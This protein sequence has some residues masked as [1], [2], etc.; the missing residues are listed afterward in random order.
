M[1]RSSPLESKKFRA[2][3]FAEFSWK[4]LL[5]CALTLFAED[6]QHVNHWA[7]WFMMSI[8]VTAGFV[9]IGYIGGQAWLDRYVRVAEI[10]RGKDTPSEPKQS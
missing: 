5:A 6:F 7:W 8:V 9:E 10:A 4:G 1:S 3:M 2:Y